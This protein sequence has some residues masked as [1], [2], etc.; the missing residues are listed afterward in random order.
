MS[1]DKDRVK[2][3]AK[4]VAGKNKEAFGKATGDKKTQAEGKADQAEGKAQNALGSAK[5]KAKGK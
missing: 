1:L 2:G 5:D 3:S 4:T